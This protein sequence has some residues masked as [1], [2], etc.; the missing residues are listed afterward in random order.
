MWVLPS[1]LPCH[2]STAWASVSSTSCREKSTFVVV[3]PASRAAVPVSQSSAVTVPPNGMSMCVWPSMNPGMMRAPDTSTTSAPWVGRSTPTAEIFSPVTA[4]SARKDASAVTTVPPA[5]TRSVKVCLRSSRNV[6]SGG[7]LSRAGATALEGAQQGGDHGRGEH[8]ADHRAGAPGH[9]PA[10]R[11]AGGVGPDRELLAVRERLR[12]DQRRQQRRREQRDDAREPRGQVA[13]AERD[14][15]GRLD[16][17]GGERHA[18]DQHD[19]GAHA[20]LRWSPINAPALATSTGTP[21]G[22]KGTSTSATSAPIA[23]ALRARAL[24]ASLTSSATKNAGYSASSPSA[25]GSGSESPPTAPIIVPA[26]QVTYCAAL[27]PNNSQRSNDTSLRRAI[28]HDASTTVCPCAAREA[29]LPGS[30]GASAT[31]IG[32]KREFIIAEAPI[33]VHTPPPAAMMATAVNCAE[34]ANTIADIR[35]APTGDRPACRSSTP[36]ETAR[37][38]PASANGTPARSPTRNRSALVGASWSTPPALQVSGTG[39]D[40]DD[41]RDELRVGHAQEVA[42]RRLQHRGGGVDLRDPPAQTGHRDVRPDLVG[43][44]HVAARADLAGR[45]LAADAERQ[46]EGQR[47][48]RQHDGRDQQQHVDR[49]AELRQRRHPEDGDDG[50]LGDGT[51]RAGQVHL[52]RHP[53]DLVAGHRGQHEAG[54]DERHRDQQSRQGKGPRGPRG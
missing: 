2:V 11:H 54:Q 51:E 42:G 38:P 6:P 23:P 9:E 4:T 27:A 14:R 40:R 20:S 3:P 26:V 35:I 24:R 36:K 17:E 21:A 1:A 52:L 47:D 37:S 30:E 12:D 25:C 50:D 48:G 44:L 31:P 28:A 43:P 41:R 39:V 16:R 29:A 33:A 49:H 7:N 22:A 5:S 15:P 45:R 19:L 53:V 46:G 8:A 32:R 34:P 10:R 18:G 13:A